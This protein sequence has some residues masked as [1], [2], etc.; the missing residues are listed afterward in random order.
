[1]IADLEEIGEWHN[2][3]RNMVLRDVLIDPCGE[4]SWALV[5]VSE[6]GYPKQVAGASCL[7][8][9]VHV[10]LEITLTAAIAVAS[11]LYL[12]SST[13]PPGWANRPS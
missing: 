4:M 9:V 10:P 2:V 8:F 11:S 1:M 5:R 6:V 3:F 13:L 7:D 12:T